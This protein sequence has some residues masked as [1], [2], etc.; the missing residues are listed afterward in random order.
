LVEERSKVRVWDRIE[1]F[2]YVDINY[3]IQVTAQVATRRG[4]AG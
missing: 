3:P 4:F 2:A 1:I